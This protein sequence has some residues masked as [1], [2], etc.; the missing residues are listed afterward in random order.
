MVGFV[1]KKKTLLSARGFQMSALLME[2]AGAASHY[3][4]LDL[5]LGYACR[6]WGPG[7]PGTRVPTRYVSTLLAAQLSALSLVCRAGMRIL[8]ATM[9]VTVDFS[10]QEA[11]NSNIDFNDQSALLHRQRVVPTDPTGAQ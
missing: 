2:S 7:W 6:G 9:R 8:K 3:K 5:V 4:L 10:I 11:P 1:G